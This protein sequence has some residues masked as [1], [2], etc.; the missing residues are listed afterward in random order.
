M[1]EG[2]HRNLALPKRV[3]WILPFA[4]VCACGGRQASNPPRGEVGSGGMSQGTGGVLSV[5]AASG[6]DA[7]GTGMSSEAGNVSATAG[8]AGAPQVALCVE[9]TIECVTGQPSDFGTVLRSSW[10]LVGCQQK[11]G[12]DCVTATPCP[13]QDAATFEGKGVTTIE[14]FPLGGTPGQRYKV[15][16]GFNAIASAK[17]YEGGSRDQGEMVP[18]AVEQVTSD[19]FYRDGRAVP[20]NYDTWE[21]GVFDH[22]GAEARHYYMNAFPMGGY[23]SHRTFL[24][25]YTKSIVVVGGGKITYSVHDSNCHAID[26]CGAGS[27]DAANCVDARTLP[28]E[29][30]NVTLPAMYQDAQD[31]LIK[32]TEQ[33]SALNA[34][35]VQPWHSQLGH[36]TVTAVE[37]TDDPV[38]QD[39][40]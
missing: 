32:P 7:G 28:N 27:Q 5:A 9:P 12:G 22:T 26:N 34:D 4:F 18:A 16:F 3:A 20:S 40:L 17:Y 23:E 36:L 33:L 1:N 30:R 15:T 39:Y 24:L 21:L 38:T 31:L 8:A 35:A 6:A 11:L 10:F 2:C 37:A 14:T 19:T 25:S 13:N 29:P